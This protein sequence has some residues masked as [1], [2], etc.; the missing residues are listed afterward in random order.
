MTPKQIQ[1]KIKRNEQT[2]QKF[3]SEI[4]WCPTGCLTNIRVIKQLEK[5]NYALQ[6][7]LQQK[8]YWGHC[9]NNYKVCVINFNECNCSC[10]ICK[11]QKS[12]SE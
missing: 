2:I 7:K 1:A 10:Q 12:E 5:E 4:K 11:P 6:N 9:F 8:S 3:N